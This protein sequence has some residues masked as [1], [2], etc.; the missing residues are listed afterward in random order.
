MV[1]LMGCGVTPVTETMSLTR[2]LPF[3]PSANNVA[4]LFGASNGLQG[5]NTD[6]RELQKTFSDPALGFKVQAHAEASSQ[7]I[8][9]N[10]AKQAAA[11]GD[12]GT[13]LWYFSGHGAENGLLQT[14]GGMLNFASV[15]KSMREARG[16]PFKRLI[17]IV[18]ACFSGNMVDGLTAVRNNYSVSN[19]DHESSALASGT[20][21][22]LTAIDEQAAVTKTLNNAF[23]AF[24]NQGGAVYRSAPL[25]E[26]LLV[27]SAARKSEP[28]LD[29]GARAGG[30]FTMIFRNSLA[31]LQKS[32]QQATVRDWVT[33][34]Q[35]STRRTFGHIPSYRAEPADL[36][37]NEPLFSTGLNTQNTIGAANIGRT[38]LFLGLER[39]VS[40]D[41]FDL[42]MAAPSAVASVAVCNGG[43]AECQSGAKRDILF[44]LQGD[45]SGSKIFAGTT[46]IKLTPGGGLTLLSFDASGRVLSSKTVRFKNR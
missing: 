11:V 8:I 17:V 15:A 26:Q 25:Y 16:K 42:L 20:G 12:N 43:A 7:S 45:V 23:G 36:V 32:N 6:L 27:I 30:A 14:N 38:P 34:V 33:Q 35:D 10:S 46:P 18:D 21:F 37:L 2:A 4:V 22:G 9:A 3:D 28:S 29:L 13:L 1:A 40:P 24:S 41:T 19:I 31:K 5:V 39:E 44:N